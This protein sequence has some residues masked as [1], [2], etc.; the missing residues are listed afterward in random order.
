MFSH[1]TVKASARHRLQI[2]FAFLLLA[3]PTILHAQSSDIK[4]EHFSI[5]QGMLGRGVLC[6]YQD[7]IGYLWFGTYSGVD[8]YDGY[9]FKSYRHD[10]GDLSSIANALVQTLYE[11]HEGNLWVGTARGLDML[12]RATETF[13]HFT[14]HHPILGTEQSNYISAIQED[15]FGVLWVGTHEGL[16][17]L[18]R[19]TGTFTYL[20]HDSLD[21]GSLSDDFIGAIHEDNA[22]S[23]WIGTGGGL[24][25]LDR[26]TGKFMHFLHDQYSIRSIYE[27]KSGMLW[28]GTTGGLLEFDQTAGT[29]T[30]YV[31]DPANP[32]SLS[33]D[34]VSSICKGESG[35]LWVGTLRGGLDAFDKK[36]KRFTHY[37]HD[38]KDPGSLSSN[39]I[40][41]VYRERSGTVWIGTPNQGAN[42]LNRP[43]MPFTK[44]AYENIHVTGSVLRDVFE[45]NGGKIWVG[46]SKG[47][48]QFDPETETFVRPALAEGSYPLA[49]DQAGNLWIGKESGGLYKRNQHGL[50]TGFRDSSGREFQQRVNCFCKGR[51]GALWI[52]T[53]EGG[54]FAVDPTTLTVTLV[55]Q[56]KVQINNIHED[57]FGL[58]WIGTWQGGLLCYD[59]GKQTIARYTSDSRDTA[60]LGSNTVLT[61]YEDKTGTLWFGVRGL[62][63]YDRMNGTFTHFGPKEG[64]TNAVFE[65]LEDDHADLWLSTEKGVSKFDRKNNRFKHYDVSYGLEG[66]QFR[67]QSGCRTKNGEMY[68]GGSSGLA[69]FHPDSIRDNPFV[70]PIVLTTF[71]KF[72]KPFPLEKEIRLPHTDN[73]ISFEFAALSYVSPERNKYAY[74]ME[75][76]DNDWVYSGTRRYAGYPHLEPGEYVFRVK[77]SNN[78]GV[79]NEEGTSIAVI[80][81]PP[82]WAT[83][84]FR[85]IF[86][87]TIAG[88]IAGT[89]RY[90]E[91]TKLRRRMRVLEQ[92]QALEHE[93][94]RISNDLHDELASNLSSIAMLSKILDEK[95]LP[96]K[97]TSDEHPQ[98]M[99]R[100]MSLSQESVDSIRDIIWA[101]D[102]KSETLES[103]FT[104]LRD[105]VIVSCRA[106]N[107]QWGFDHSSAEPLPSANLAPEMRSHLWLLLKEA[108][109]NALKHSACTEL[110]L[111]VKYADGVLSVRVQDNGS[112]F[113]QSKATSGKGSRTMRMRAEQMGGKLVHESKPGEGTVV[114]LDVWI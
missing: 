92:Q 70:P 19:T 98:L 54:I 5:E 3:L 99:K 69:R 114:E 84:W 11:D 61:I 62:D 50:L 76:L 28:L 80:I 16:K 22:G 111:C 95:A 38:E 81:T 17:T 2:F 46:T 75:G 14:P 52:G 10:P 67:P 15:K 103:L 40:L 34:N 58:L 78:D 30:Q 87:L 25:K 42:K 6:I 91:I 1:T 20:R 13:S 113:D 96:E 26:E 57:A 105:M 36:S 55:Q 7:S 45:D 60:R 104:R 94:L 51:S 35:A 101:I 112:G 79:W 110:S 23:L 109:N 68:F 59:R 18:D 9:S 88:S 32:Q 12:D 64:L 82:F 8:R 33:S 43:K 47:W 4:F 72:E 29:F 53:V 85:T 41:S 102:P 108:V 66:N 65:I 31:H 37:V 49:E 90:I 39:G 97:R 83:W 44:Y 107:I 27:D 106:K 48:E 89:V 93:R 63:R 56:T 77:G 86:W 71:R 73:F 74:K 21:A 100:I 24:D